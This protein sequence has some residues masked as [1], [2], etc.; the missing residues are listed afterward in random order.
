[1]KHPLRSIRAALWL[2]CSVGAAGQVQAQVAAPCTPVPAFPAI[3]IVPIS[4]GLATYC[5]SDYGWSDAWFVGSAPVVYDPRL[6]V[7]SGDDA[8]NLH[9]G[10]RGGA[11]WEEASGFGWISPVMDGGFL[12][13]IRPTGSPWTVTTPV[14]LLM[15]TTT[16]TSVVSHPIGL[17]LAI[18]TTL[19]P[20]GQEI[21][22]TFTLSN[23][24]TAL[25][26]EDIVFADYFNFHPNGSDVD[27]FRLG[28]MTYSPLG[29]LR[30]TGPDDGTLIAFGSMRGE[31]VDDWHGT[32]FTF[33]T[34]PDIAIDQAQTLIYPDQTLPDEAFTA[35]PGDA[36]GSL[37]WRL[38][39]LAPGES[40]SFTI[41]KLAEPLGRVVEPGALWLLSLGLLT[42]ALVRR[43]A[44]DR[45][46][47]SGRA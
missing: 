20:G 14:S 31:R 30:V 2:A 34:V 9:F 3:N 42:A 29:G 11:R 28:T 36:A 38:D 18:E 16:A 26:F 41:F 13:P 17:E 45:D 12:E 10:I 8:P 23:V 37:A 15:G 27:N 1:M 39:P 21:R 7:L 33:A 44:A 43:Q 6:D 47:P 35:G 22:Q 46:S 19:E 24:S 5:V 4:N 25:T 40:V 32:N